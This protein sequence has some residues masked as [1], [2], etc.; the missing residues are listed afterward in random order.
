MKEYRLYRK[1]GNEFNTQLHYVP[2]GVDKPYYATIDEA[3]QI[4]ETSIRARA[5]GSESA[6]LLDFSDSRI[7]CGNCDSTGW[8][9]EDHRNLPFEGL[10]DNGCKCGG[11]GMIC[12]ECH[13]ETKYSK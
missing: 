1:Q 10:S 12:D 4:N 7:R 3:I 9:C 6:V 13:I 2:N 11:A 8:V 5:K